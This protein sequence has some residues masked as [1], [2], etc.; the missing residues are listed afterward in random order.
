MTRL[1]T[2][3]ID[4]SYFLFC[5]TDSTVRQRTV[6]LLKIYHSIL[7]EQINALGSNGH[8]LFPLDK[9]LWHFKSYCKFGLGNSKLLI[10]HTKKL[11]W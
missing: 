1:G 7:V 10:L 6:E 8:N 11:L 5:C 4:L 9:L 3:S 2:V